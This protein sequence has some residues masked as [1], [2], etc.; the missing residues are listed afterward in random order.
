MEEVGTGTCFTY[1]EA[2]SLLREISPLGAVTRYAYDEKGNA[3]RQ[4]VDGLGTI[5]MTYEGGLLT[6]ITDYNG[7]LTSFGYD[8]WGNRCLQTDAMGNS[9]EAVYDET[10]KILL[11]KGFDGTVTAY[12]Y[13]A[14]GQKIEETVTGEDGKTRTVRYGYDGMGRVADVT[15]EAGTTA[16]TLSLIH[17]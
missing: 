4:V 14:K 5:T 3:V 15:N 6:G 16:Y 1:D 11:E 8:E 13:D 2:G 9:M 10:G 17:I 7:G 12:T